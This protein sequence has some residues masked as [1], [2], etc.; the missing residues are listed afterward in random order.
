MI[1]DHPLSPQENIVF[2]TE[3]VIRHNGAKLLNSVTASIPM[4][5]YLLLDIIGFIL[6]ATI[7]VISSLYLSVKIVFSLI[8][9]HLR[10]DEKDKKN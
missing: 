1:K 7:A 8:Q 10:H 3:Y 9:K 4:Y 2:W 6:L 5:Q